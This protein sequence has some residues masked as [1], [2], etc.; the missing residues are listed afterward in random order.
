MWKSI[1]VLFPADPILAHID[2]AEK[3]ITRSFRDLPLKGRN[4]GLPYSITPPAISLDVKG[5]ANIVNVLETSEVFVVYVDLEGL[6]P[7]VFVRRAT[8]V[9]PVTTALVGVETRTFTV[10]IKK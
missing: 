6:K 1:T 9:L 4:T 2:I 5:P 3:L 10:T 8:I 7:G